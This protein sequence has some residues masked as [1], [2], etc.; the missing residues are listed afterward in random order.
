VRIDYSDDSFLAPR[1]YF[2]EKRNLTLLTVNDISREEEIRINGKI[3]GN[4]FIYVDGEGIIRIENL[5]DKNYCAN[6]EEGNITITPNETGEIPEL[7]KELPL[8]TLNGNKIVYVEIG[9]EYKEEGAKARTIGGKELEYTTEIRYKNEI[10]ERVDTSKE[11]EYIITYSTT[12]GEKTVSVTR[13]VAVLEMKPVITM[14][15]PNENYVKEQEV[16]ITVSGIR[17]NKVERFKIEIKKNGEEIRSEEVEGLTKRLTLN[18]SGSYEIKVRATDNNGHT[19][20]ISKIYRISNSKPEI[21]VNPEKVTLRP[22]EVVGYNILAGVRVTDEVDGE[23]ENSKII[24]TSNL[25]TSPGIY[26][27]TYTVTNSIG[28]TSVAVRIVE[29]IKQTL[30]DAGD[31]GEIVTDTDGND[32]YAG[33]NPDNWVCFGNSN[34]TNPTECDDNYKW[35]IIGSFDGKLKIITNYYSETEKSFDTSDSNNWARPATLNTELNGSSFYSND[36]YIDATHREYINNA[37]WYIGGESPA[38]TYT[39]QTF[40]NGEKNNSTTG[41]VGLMSIVDFGYAGSECT[42]TLD[43]STHKNACISNNWLFNTSGSPLTLTPFGNSDKRVWVIWSGGGIGTNSAN[44]TAPVVR[45]AVF[46]NNDVGIIAGEGTE[47]N[48]SLLL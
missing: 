33:S 28:N 47:S 48:P 38:G 32:R 30:P 11:G 25:S 21:I 3:N 31:N 14:T 40:I 24:T 2:Y 36:S 18:E 19:N 5:C 4:G 7:N 46:L 8:I 23:I 37:T 45:P 6:G 1:E 9:G 29:V 13:T 44:E 15:E 35:R 39:L 26:T 41:Y 42:L 22:S 16:L 27:I 20:E 34:I 17:P 12:S 43:I 10:V